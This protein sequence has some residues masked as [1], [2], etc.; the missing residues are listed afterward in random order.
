MTLPHHDMSCQATSR[1][2]SEGS[3][4]AVLPAPPARHLLGPASWKTPCRV[5]GEEWGS[6][7]RSTGSRKSIRNMIFKK[8]IFDLSKCMYVVWNIKSVDTS[9]TEALSDSASLCLIH[10]LTD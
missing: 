10:L 5:Q 4:W 2:G 7:S 1:A 6:C 8:P 3:P 9:A